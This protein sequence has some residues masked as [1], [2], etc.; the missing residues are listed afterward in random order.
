MQFPLLPF[1]AFHLRRFR[2]T[3]PVLFVTLG[4]SI[5]AFVIALCASLTMVAAGNEALSRYDSMKATPAKSPTAV[6]TL[7]ERGE[8]LRP[9]NSAQMVTALNEVGARIGVAVNE[10][11]FTFD[12]GKTEPFIRYRASMT[13]NA[14]YLAVR[15]YVDQVHADIPDTSL[16]SISCTR[17]GIDDALVTCELAFT[18]FFKKEERG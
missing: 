13:L 14:N 5:L 2:S 7:P 10:L 1:L 15:R 8:T 12:E 3:Q 17:K 9:F 16:D 18:A 11:T 4:L 6:D